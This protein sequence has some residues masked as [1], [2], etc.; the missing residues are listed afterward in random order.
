MWLLEIRPLCGWSNLGQ[1]LL[2]SVVETALLLT[3]K[4]VVTPNKI[5]HEA[6]PAGHAQVHTVALILCHIRA[7]VHT[8]ECTNWAPSYPQRG[9]EYESTTET[10]RQAGWDER[11]DRCPS[12]LAYMYTGGM[13]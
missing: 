11:V 8:S 3:F 7:L 6:T 13:I 10:R 5:I 12:V 1:A 2:Y 9:P 4:V